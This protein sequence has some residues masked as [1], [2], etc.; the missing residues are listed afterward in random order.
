MCCSTDVPSGMLAS[1]Q[2]LG[3]LS[4]FMSLDLLLHN[5]GDYYTVK[6]IYFFGFG[7]TF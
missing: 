2:D 7:V 6:H 4:G 1:T 5:S 3:L